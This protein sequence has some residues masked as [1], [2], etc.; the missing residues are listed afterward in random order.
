MFSPLVTDRLMVR[1]VRPSDVDALIERRNAP[2]VAEFQDWP[3]PCERDAAEELLAEAA[4]MDGPTPGEWWMST[5][6]DGADTV[7]HGDFNVRLSNDGV[8][9]IGYALAR[10]SW[11]QGFATEAL[12]AVTSWLF[13]THDVVRIDATI[14][15]K[16]FRSMRMVENCGFVLAGVDY[17][18]Q[19]DRHGHIDDQRYSLTPELYADWT[20]RPRHVPATIELV[21]LDPNE[22]RSV[23]E[24]VTH[25]SQRRFASPIVVSLAEA[26]VPPYELNSE[27]TPGS[28][29]VVPWHRI[30]HADGQAVGFVMI[31]TPTKTDP[32]PYLWR[33]LI[34]RRHQR[35]G[36]GKR[37]VELV[38]D[39]ARSWGCESLAV[40]YGQGVGSPEPLY[41]AMGF[42]PT[43]EIEEG[44]I[45][46]RL[47]L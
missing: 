30:I 18:T 22:V 11:G 6:A 25:P 28:P 21:E 19:W 27:G 14:H 35:R 1:A 7:V 38:I 45:V 41:L 3:L 26:A 5:I 33:L 23:I 20:S 44:E 2:E 12:N 40:S 13:E 32:E 39:Q 31:E 43:G 47:M 34:D 29:Q 10:E 9:A 24:L 4:S 37:V 17:N 16:N 46:A 36:I 8:A 15:P 42:V